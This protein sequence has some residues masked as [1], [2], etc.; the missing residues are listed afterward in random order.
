MK[1]CWLV[2][3]HG[4]YYHHGEDSFLPEWYETKARAL[5]EMRHYRTKYLVDCPMSVAR[6]DVRRTPRA[7]APR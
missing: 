6:F 2:K 3:V 7:K 1:R 5:R 4:S